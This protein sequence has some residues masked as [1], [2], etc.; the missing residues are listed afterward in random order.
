MEVFLT[1]IL[2]VL[3]LLMVKQILIKAVWLFTLEEEEP[4]RQRNVVEIL[5][6]ILDPYGEIRSDLSD[7]KVFVAFQY[8]L[9][10]NGYI[11]RTVEEDVRFMLEQDTSIER[12]NQ[13][14]RAVRRITSGSKEELFRYAKEEGIK[15]TTKFKKNSRKTIKRFLLDELYKGIID[16]RPIVEEEILYG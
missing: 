15:L 6:E 10:K 11:M 8:V 2:A 3:L 12:M 5:Q 7:K 14:T 9:M 4:W 1:V 13:R 16:T